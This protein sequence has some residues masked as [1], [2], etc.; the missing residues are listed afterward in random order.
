MQ[1][2]LEMTWQ[3][4]CERG[5]SRVT[6]TDIRKPP[7]HQC[8]LIPHNFIAHKLYSSQP[9]ST[10][11]YFATRCLRILKVDLQV[12]LLA[13]SLAFGDNDHQSPG[14]PSLK[15]MMIIIAFFNPSE[16]WMVNYARDWV[17]SD[18]L[19]NIPC[20]L[21]PLHHSCRH[22]HHHHCHYMKFAHI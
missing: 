12:W 18:T 15:M 7:T 6:D 16:T 8:H 17:A 4:S 21:L 10:Q 13:V 2:R 22:H 20:V 11:F 3:Q 1:W 5:I 9:Q 19:T 14:H